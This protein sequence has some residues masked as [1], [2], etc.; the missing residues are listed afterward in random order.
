[1]IDTEIFQNM[2]SKLSPN[3]IVKH[4]QQILLTVS[5]HKARVMANRLILLDPLSSKVNISS[6]SL[7]IVKCR[8]IALSSYDVYGHYFANILN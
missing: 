8:G 3:I 5:Q 6:D 1:M 7:A 4:V 2:I